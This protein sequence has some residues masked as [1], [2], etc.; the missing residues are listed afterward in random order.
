MKQC[1]CYNEHLR[2]QINGIFLNKM[3]KNQNVIVKPARVETKLT[4]ILIGKTNKDTYEM[5]V[6]IVITTRIQCQIGQSGRQ[7][8]V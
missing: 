7:I 5:L 4:L 1:L 8:F 6:L 2:R 3:R